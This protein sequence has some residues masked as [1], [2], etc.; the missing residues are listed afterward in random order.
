M[1]LEPGRGVDEAECFRTERGE[2]FGV[3]DAEVIKV[4]ERGDARDPAQNRDEEGR[5]SVEGDD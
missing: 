3:E 1:Q 2:S 4:V 5:G